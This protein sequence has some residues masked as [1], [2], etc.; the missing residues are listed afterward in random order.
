MRLICPLHGELQGTPL[1]YHLPSYLFI[2][3]F[4]TQ[5]EAY[6][7]VACLDYVLLVRDSIL[8]HQTSTILA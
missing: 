6:S 2:I 4:N 8:E 5:P 7:S 1:I 3:F